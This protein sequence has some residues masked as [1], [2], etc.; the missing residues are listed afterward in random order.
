MRLAP[1]GKDTSARR[2]EPK[3]VIGLSGNIQEFV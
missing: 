1:F 2:D 3:K